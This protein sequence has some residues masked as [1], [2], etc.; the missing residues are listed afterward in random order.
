MQPGRRDSFQRP[1]DVPERLSGLGGEGY[2][3]QV[4]DIASGN[5]CDVESGEA[6]MA[7][8]VV[9]RL[10]SICGIAGN[11]YVARDLRKRV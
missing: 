3:L 5:A 6:Q 4:G 2:A 7:K 8:E 1:L 11:R 10:C 9:W